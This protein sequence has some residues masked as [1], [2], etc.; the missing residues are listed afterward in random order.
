MQFIERKI[1]R[2]LLWTFVYITLIGFV[3]L[4]T[5]S[6]IYTIRVNKAPYVDNWIDYEVKILSDHDVMLYKSDLSDSI[7]IRL[8]N[9][10]NLSGEWMIQ[11][12]YP[13]KQLK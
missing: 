5:Y 8:E 13:I 6:I 10:N 7:H 4:I 9:A 3:I 12:N 11:V 2:K 1:P